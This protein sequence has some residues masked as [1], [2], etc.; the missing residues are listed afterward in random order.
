MKNILA[1]TD[2]SSGSTNAIKYALK[3]FEGNSLDFYILHCKVPDSTYTTAEVVASGNASFYDSLLKEA[4]EKL[5]NLIAD[6][7]QD[8]GSKSIS[9]HPIVSYN[10]LIDAVKNVIETKNIHLSVM[11]TNGVTNAKE[12]V[13]G[14][15]TVK[16]IKQITHPILAVPIDFNFSKLKN[17]VDR[18]SVV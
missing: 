17:I 2:F 13:F 7:K 9:F 1:L 11:G 3:L 4:Q 6:L 18:K 15:N 16:M 12:A 5:D 10:S 14:S 8:F